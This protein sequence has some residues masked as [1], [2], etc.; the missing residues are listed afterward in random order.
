MELPVKY[1]ELN[2]TDKK[3]VRARYIKL[4]EN[5]CWYCRGD[6]NKNPPLEI[7]NKKINWNHFPDGFLNYPIHLQH[8]HYTGLTEGAVHAYCNAVLW[9]Y[10]GR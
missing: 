3:L 6:L 8:N 9:E 4:Q 1:N 5:K 10:Y 2:S 7:I